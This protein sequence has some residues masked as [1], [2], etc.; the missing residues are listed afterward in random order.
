LFQI[1]GP[2]RE[3]P[4]RLRVVLSVG[5]GGSAFSSRHDARLRCALEAG[6]PTFVSQE[7]KRHE[8]T[9]YVHCLKYRRDILPRVLLGGIIAVVPILSVAADTQ[10]AD[11]HAAPA[12]LVQHVREATRQ[13][14]DV[15]AAQRRATGIL[16]LFSRSDQRRDGRAL[17]QPRSVR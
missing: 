4:E 6:T 3:L 12:K 9:N 1:V 2:I 14:I 5:V 10:A 7:E 8:N 15:N 13:F 16:G 17:H 11:V